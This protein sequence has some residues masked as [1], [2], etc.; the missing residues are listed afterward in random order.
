MCSFIEPPDPAKPLL[1]LP[2]VVLS[3]HN[4]AAPLACNDED[5]GP[6]GEEHA[7][8]VRR[9]AR[10]RV[11]GEPGDAAEPAECLRGLRYRQMITL[12]PRPDRVIHG[13]STRRLARLTSPSVT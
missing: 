9:R 6:L 5:V 3:S 8:A 7:G 11:C 4:A 10:P 1:K 12:G 2:N 13:T